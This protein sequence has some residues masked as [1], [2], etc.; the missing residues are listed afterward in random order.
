MRD[1]SWRNQRRRKKDFSKAKR[2]Q[3]ICRQVHV[4][5][6]WYDNLHQYSKNKIHCSCQMCRFRS[7]WEPNR[8]PMADV[9]KIE[10][11]NYQQKAFQTGDEW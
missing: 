11:M 8:R 3:K 10:G 4:N 5:P 7:D 1:S 2:K 9:R 6:N